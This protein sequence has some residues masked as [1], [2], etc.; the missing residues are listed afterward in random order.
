MV[1]SRVG[2]TFLQHHPHPHSWLLGALIYSP[3]HGLCIAI[4]KSRK[5]KDQGDRLLT[6]LLGWSDYGPGTWLWASVLNGFGLTTGIMRPGA[7]CPDPLLIME[8]V[9]RKV[10]HFAISA[11]QRRKNIKNVVLILYSNYFYIRLYTQ[12]CTVFEVWIPAEFGDE[13]LQCPKVSNITKQH[14]RL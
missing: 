10:F 8:K 11:Q 13:V 14:R 2:D 7:S 1:T 4:K 6:L 9:D 5:S 3:P 12:L